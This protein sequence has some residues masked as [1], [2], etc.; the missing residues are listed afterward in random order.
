MVLNDQQAV[1]LQKWISGMN[2]KVT[3]VPGAGKSRVM[4]ESCKSF[5]D[6]L[7]LILAYNHDLCEETNHKIAEQGLQDRVICM[8]FHGL[9]TYCIM[10]CYDD[11]ALFDAIEGVETGELEVKNR[12]SVSGVMIDEAQD[13]RPSFERVLRLVLDLKST[14][15]YMVVG[16]ANQMLYTYDE[17]DSADLKYLNEANTNFISTREWVHVEFFKTHR[18]T[19]PMARVVSKIFDINL[20]SAKDENLERHLPVQLY[21][22]NLWKAGAYIMNMIKNVNLKDVVVL[23]PKKKNNGP[24]RAALNFLSSKGIRIY[25]HGTDGQDTRI[26]KNKLCVG[27]WH[28][29]KGT[30]QNIVIVLG[31]T[32]EAQR[33]P[34][35]V[36]LTRGCRQLVII[37]D[38]K[39]PYPPLMKALHFL[40]END[41]LYCNK[42]LELKNHGF[43]IQERPILNFE[44]L[45][46]YSLDNV[47]LSGTGRWIR[48]HQLI[49][50]VRMSTISSD[51]QDIVQVN[52]VHEDVSCIY[53]SACLMAVEYKLTGKVRILEDI[54]APLRLTRPQQDEAILNDHHSRFISP[55]IP[56]NTL[57]GDDMN[58]IILSYTKGSEIQPLQWCELACLARSWNDYHHNL[59]QLKP[60]VWFD[61]EKFRAACLF[62]LEILHNQNTEFDVRVKRVSPTFTNMTLYARVHAL[63]ENGIYHTVWANEISHTD[64]INATIRAALNRRPVSY[65]INLRTM[66]I[67]SIVVRDCETVL[68]TVISR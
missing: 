51:D 14:V 21:S 68:S 26:R 60:F 15:Q 48:N 32:S 57:V 9:A 61:I 13:F 31:L 29:S 1:A 58:D 5:S 12:L 28:S 54:N 42:T 40:D 56:V 35:F 62:L 37:Q 30:E 43:S 39:N 17:E 47:R 11:M 45:T 52:E 3:A 8:T 66:Y 34:C 4:L 59:R 19:P 38:E 63:S 53:A 44:T 27:T 10:P 7:I 67:E 50:M 49:E 2:V 24:L 18:L 36:A 25:L 22:I 64:R 33:N 65:V 16:D 20:V 55:N 46:T 41:I 23:V 6:G